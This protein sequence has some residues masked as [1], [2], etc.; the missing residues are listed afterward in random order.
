[1]NA[2]RRREP[3]LDPAML[4]R[5]GSAASSVPR[6]ESH[7]VR[8]TARSY[9]PEKLVSGLDPDAAALLGGPRLRGA[10]TLRHGDGRG[11]VSSRHYVARARA[12]ALERGLRAA[13]AAAEGWPLWR[14]PEPAAALLPVPGDPQ[15]VA[16]GPAGSVPEVALRDRPRPQDPR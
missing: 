4:R 1:C 13:I 7:D 3:A 8:R 14:E 11:H 12:E 15:A 9:E 2:R 5:I 6:N 16:A 10:A